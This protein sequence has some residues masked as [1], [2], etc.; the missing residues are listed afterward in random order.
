MADRT[1]ADVFARGRRVLL[2]A[3]SRQRRTNEGRT[4]T[5]RLM[6]ATV[7]LLAG[8]MVVVSAINA[9]GTDLRPGRDTDLVS[10]VQSQSRRN[11]D[12]TRE[13]TALRAEVDRKS[14]V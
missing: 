8:L 10:L 4:S 6:T 1:F 12:L 13:V 5:G 9:R 14:V 2:R 7:C 3:S 11:A